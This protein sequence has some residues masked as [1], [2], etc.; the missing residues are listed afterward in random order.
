M[1]ILS[2]KIILSF[3]WAALLLLIAASLIYDF[4]NIIYIVLGM[5]FASSSD[6][7]WRS[8]RNSGDESR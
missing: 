5:S 4:G 3:I 7:F 1:N 8:I 6:V 2:G